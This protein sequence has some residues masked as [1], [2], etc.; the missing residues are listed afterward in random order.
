MSSNFCDLMI[1]DE[2]PRM[3]LA[4]Y[5]ML[6]DL[7]LKIQIYQRGE[8]ALANFKQCRPQLFLID[9]EAHDCEGI[10]LV[11]KLLPLVQ[12][13][14]SIVLMV[15]K[16]AKDEDLKIFSDHGLQKIVKKPLHQVELRGLIMD[17]MKEF[18]V[19]KKAS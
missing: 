1:I 14:D 4:I 17:T 3:G 11:Q 7:G 13:K 18:N 6:K 19:T 10:C 9:G 2:D 16:F 15:S 8:E 12:S 5:S